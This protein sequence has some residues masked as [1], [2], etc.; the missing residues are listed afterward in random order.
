M[1]RAL[2]LA[3][4]L[5][6]ALPAL[7]QVQASRALGANL[8]VLDKITGEVSDLDLMAGTAQEVGLLSIRLGECRFPSGNPNGDAYAQL[9]IT[10]NNLA[11]PAFA[12]WMIASAPALNAMDH[13]RYDVWVL[14]CIT[15]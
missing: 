14:R 1:I 5:V 6:A 12:G 7:A 2:F 15:S 3:A 11:E 9:T 4:T 8:R 13:P 10:Y